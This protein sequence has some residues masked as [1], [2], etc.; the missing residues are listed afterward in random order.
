M[1]I[2]FHSSSVRTR[3]LP[4]TCHSVISGQA[5]WIWKDSESSCWLIA[6]ECRAAQTRNTSF[7]VSRIPLD[8]ETRLF[9]ILQGESS[10]YF[11][12]RPSIVVVHGPEEIR[13]APEHRRHH[14]VVG[15]VDQH[16]RHP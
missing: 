10:N 11:I 14:C 1:S 3:R 2:G 12:N 5:R 7:P 16:V 4:N 8:A 13:V 6:S 15:G 9:S